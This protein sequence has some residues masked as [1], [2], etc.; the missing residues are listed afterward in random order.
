MNRVAGA[1]AGRPF[2]R[3]PRNHSSHAS[4]IVVGF[5]A[6]SPPLE[7]AASASA[8][9]DFAS[10]SRANCLADLLP[11]ALRVDGRLPSGVTPTAPAVTAG[12]ALSSVAS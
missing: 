3:R 6:R 4:L 2:Q 10:A 5:G 8:R 12:A 7:R 11:V 9:Q 1:V